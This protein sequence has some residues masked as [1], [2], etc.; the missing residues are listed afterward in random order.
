MLGAKR[1]IGIDIDPQALQASREN[2]SRNGVEE[3]LDLYLPENVP[4]LKADIVIANILA[5]PL[6]ELSG[7]ISQYCEIGGQL[8]MSGILQEQADSVIY[9]YN[10]EFSF[11]PLANDAEWIRL[12]A[13]KKNN[14]S[15][16]KS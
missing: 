6:R 12:S 16:P 9:R 5:A 14:M 2:A 13:V 3:R 1:V 15:S 4:S 8:V 7:T 10:N 11:E